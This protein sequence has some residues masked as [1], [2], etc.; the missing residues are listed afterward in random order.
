MVNNKKAK[1]PLR[2]VIIS[3]ILKAVLG[4]ALVVECIYFGIVIDAAKTS[5]ESVLSAIVTILGI[6]FVEYICIIFS[7]YTVNRAAEIGMFNLRKSIS[8][9]ICHLKFKV[10]DETS[11]GDILSRT[12]GDLNG[13]GTFW[14]NT[15]MD[16]YTNVFCFIGGFGVC[17]YVSWQLTIIG[18]IFI[19][20]VSF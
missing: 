20:I 10:F 17:L 13:V 15:F 14:T 7:R 9:K 11:T 18:F 2:L 16:A 19:P 12:M 4:V 5:M 1:V 3:F 6:T 8:K